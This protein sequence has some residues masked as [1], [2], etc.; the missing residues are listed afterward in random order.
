MSE[1]TGTL[2]Y[3][4]GPPKGRRQRFLNIF[5][6]LLG[7]PEYRDV[8]WLASTDDPS[9]GDVSASW[10]ANGIFTIDENEADR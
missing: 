1:V 7:R 10:S 3:S 2:I 6:R 9:A 5:R 4:G 8:V